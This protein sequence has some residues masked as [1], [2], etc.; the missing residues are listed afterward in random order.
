M[1]QLGGVVVLDRTAGLRLRGR[2]NRRREDAVRAA[3]RTARRGCVVVITTPTGGEERRAKSASARDS[4]SPATR[5]A[6]AHHF[7]P[8]TR[9]HDSPFFPC[10][11]GTSIHDS[12]GIKDY[13]CTIAF[14]SNLARV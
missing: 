5:N 10:E 11:S 8:V 7:A 9:I 3:A 4:H 12:N 6:R 14:R 2:V 1:R 13:S